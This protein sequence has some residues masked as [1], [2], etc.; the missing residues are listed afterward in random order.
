MALTE[1]V[2]M[3]GKDYKNICDSVRKKTGTND[4]YTSD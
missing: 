1:L 2:I 3:P 4:S